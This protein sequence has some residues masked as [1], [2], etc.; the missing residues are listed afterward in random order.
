MG[1]AI[2]VHVW[3]ERRLALIALGDGVEPA[4]LPEHGL[5]VG[6]FEHLRAG[7]ILR[8]GSTEITRRGRRVVA[9]ARYLRDLHGRRQRADVL[10]HV[11]NPDSYLPHPDEEL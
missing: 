9:D 5:P 10:P 4:L 11:D 1:E 8:V 3:F 2:V 7:D 6:G